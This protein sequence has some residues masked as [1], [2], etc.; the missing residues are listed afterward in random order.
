MRKERIVAGQKI[1]IYSFEL[2]DSRMYMIKGINSVLIVDP[3]CDSQLLK[4]VEGIKEGIVYLTHEHFDHISGVNWL[5]NVLN[6][7]VYA[8]NTCAE[9][10]TSKTLNATKRFPLLFLGDKEKYDYAKKMVKQPYICTADVTFNRELKIRWEGHSLYMRKTTGHSPGSSMMQ[11]DKKI[12]FA[13]DSLLGNGMELRSVG[14][15]Q[16]EYQRNIVGYVSQLDRDI[17]V[18]PGHG[19]IN[20]LGYFVEKL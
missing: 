11:I 12:L 3:L 10:M 6:V 7:V 8:S 18:C 1:Y 14:A 4:D 16:K 17:M 19:E 20:N 5:R 13:G 9:I 15:S 2:I